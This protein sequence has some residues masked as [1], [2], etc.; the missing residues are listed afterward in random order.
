MGRVPPPLPLTSS[1]DLRPPPCLNNGLSRTSVWVEWLLPLEQ[2]PVLME[3]LPGGIAQF[4]VIGSGGDAVS[5]QGSVSAVGSGGDASLHGSVQVLVVLGV[6]THLGCVPIA[7][8][9]E[10]KGGW[11]CPCHG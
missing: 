9:G 6:C 3:E 7:N 5:G 2:R 4:L 10:F 11:F 1:N 8:A